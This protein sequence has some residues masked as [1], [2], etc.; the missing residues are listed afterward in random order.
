MAQIPQIY[1]IQPSEATASYDYADIQE[2]T[3]TT[4]Y[5][6]ANHFSV[7]TSG[8]SQ[9]S[10]EREYFLT[11]ES[12]I[13]SHDI[14]TGQQANSATYNFDVVF[15]RPQNIKGDVKVIGTIGAVVRS[16]SPAAATSGGVMIE[17]THVDGSTSTETSMGSKISEFYTFTAQSVNERTSFPFLTQVNVPLTHFKVNDKFR[18]KITV[19]QGTTNRQMG[20]GHDP[21]NRED[22]GPEGDG[23]ISITS[24]G[25]GTFD[26]QLAVHVPFI[27]KT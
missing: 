26:T 13:K 25:I 18:M 14:S 19:F 1:P 9:S 10:A 17:P 2:G 8:S 20:I 12:S 11:R 23:I 15:A 3:G 7:A 24:T 22:D 4:I 27:L 6:G 5:Y 21:A 16:G